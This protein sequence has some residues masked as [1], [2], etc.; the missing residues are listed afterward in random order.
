MA[1]R[2]ESFIR[3]LFLDNVG[4]KAVSLAAAMTL[5]WIVRGSE[6]AQRSVF[7]DVIAVLPPA[8]ANEMLTTELPAKVRLTLRGSRSLLNNVRADT[9]PAVQ[10]DLREPGAVVYYFEAERFELPSGIEV[11]EIAP[12]SITLAWADRATRTVA[13]RPRVSGTVDDGLMLVGDP[14][15]RPATVTIRGAAPDI[16]ILDALRT[17]PI[18]ITGLPAGRHERRVELAMPV[19]HLEIVDDS[20]VSVTLEIAPEIAER[21]IPRQEISVTGG[22]L[23]EIRPNRVR[24][25]LRGSPSVLDALDAPSIVPYVDASGLDPA[26]GTQPILVRVRGVPEGVEL[27]GVEPEEVLATPAAH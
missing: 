15:V 19:G 2:Q 18:D 14:S 9:L 23:R 10:V 8:T 25:I 22:T 1:V 5:F 3:G 12:A 17:E 20:V 13:V 7:V 21:A 4:L 26:L 6:D 11:T 24:I 27:V 16:A